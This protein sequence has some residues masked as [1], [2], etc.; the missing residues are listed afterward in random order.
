M[1]REIKT[2]VRVEH[3]FLDDLV[4]ALNAPVSLGPACV[5]VRGGRRYLPK[6]RSGEA[7]ATRRLRNVGDAAR[8]GGR[9]QRAG[10]ISIRAGWEDGASQLGGGDRRG[11]PTRW[12][13]LEFDRGTVE[14]R[15]YGLRLRR[16]PH[17][18]LSGS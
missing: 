8:V 10:G 11:Q 7:D 16:Y 6:R 14:L 15:H 12:I 2:R 4:D 17:F 3:R 1:R 13:F 18:Y 5:R 9:S